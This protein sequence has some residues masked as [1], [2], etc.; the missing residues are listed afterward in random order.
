LNGLI[1]RSMGREFGDR[2]LPRGLEITCAIRF[3]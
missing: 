2:L 3:S 1:L